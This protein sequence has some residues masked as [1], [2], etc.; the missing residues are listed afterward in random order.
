MF[1]RLRFKLTILYAG[2]FCLALAFISITAYVVV[3]ESAGDMV[4]DELVDTGNVFDRVWQLRFQQLE[5]GATLSARDYGFTQAIATGDNAT[6]G[7]ALGNVRRRLEADV[8]FIVTPQGTIVTERGTSTVAPPHLQEALERE[9]EPT[10][11]LM[12]G[13]MPHQAVSA[14]I[15]A[16]NLLGWMIVA[17][18]LDRAEMQA[19][20]QL[21]SIP[22]DAAALV[23]AES[24]QWISGDTGAV[25]DPELT[26]FVARALELRQRDPGTLNGE[27]GAALALVRPFQSLDGTAS[28]LLLR[29]PM[30]S[31][32]APYQ[33]LFGSLLATCLV[34]LC[35]VLIGGWMI[36]RSITRPLSEL[37]ASARRLQE[38]EHVPVV[39]GSRD[40][41]SRLAETFNAM[42]ATI[43]ARERRIT[44]L[45]L[46]D[47]ET[48]LPNRRALERKLAVLQRRRP[49]V[50][51]A[52][53]I[54]RFTHMRG[55]IGY[56]HAS[57]LISRI[58]ERLERLAPHA[59][60]A[61]LSTDVLGLVLQAKDEADARA[62]MQVLLE[63][64]EH[65]VAIDDQ[66]VDVSV[67]IGAAIPRTQ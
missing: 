57:A 2:L 40:E 16:P 59:P 61:L 34:S 20:E 65:P 5:D 39:V 25:H 48:R 4:R 63:N 53:G 13:G 45:A 36:A 44:H 38:G 3:R 32:M 37:E 41:I 58:G 21:S 43:Q 27:G 29:Y 24:G 6:I 56:A 52:I 67:S 50:V 51:A 18:R 12:A 9:D 46:H 7:S 30:S 17:E 42:A 55:A 15:Y 33:T 23:R 14:P 64:L 1:R 22:L 10:G 54:D 11:V 49:V 62:R 28:A 26:G 31:A 35:L 19:L 66:D 60:M 8:V 47:F